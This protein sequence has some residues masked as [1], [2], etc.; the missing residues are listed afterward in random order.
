MRLSGFVSPVFVNDF[1]LKQI[2]SAMISASLLRSGLHSSFGVGGRVNRSSRQLPPWKALSVERCYL[3]LLSSFKGVCFLPNRTFRLCLR[4]F[5]PSD[6]SPNTVTE[7]WLTMNGVH[8]GVQNSFCKNWAHRVSSADCCGWLL[9]GGWLIAI[10]DMAACDFP[11][12][13]NFINKQPT[14]F[15][16]P[17][18]WSGTSASVSLCRDSPVRHWDSV[19]HT[20]LLS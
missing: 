4:M 12:F 16:G 13:H 5:S 19:V 20:T 17:L 9:V 7:Q 8:G 6:G 14:K 11:M 3:G 18:G 10:A 1:Q 15:A 2:K